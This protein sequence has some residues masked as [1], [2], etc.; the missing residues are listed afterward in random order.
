MHHTENRCLYL[1]L[2]CSR[3][4]PT[5]LATAA[6]VGSLPDCRSRSIARTVCFVVCPTLT[7]CVWCAPALIL[8]SGVAGFVF[9]C[10][11]SRDETPGDSHKHSVL[12]VRLSEL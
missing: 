1:R 4:T 10:L 7:S 8:S 12:R 6:M 3:L 11:S 2:R 9:E 5:I